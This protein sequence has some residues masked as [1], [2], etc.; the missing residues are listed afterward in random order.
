MKKM[1]VL[2][3]QVQRV[4]AL[5]ATRQRI[6]IVL[7]AVAIGAATTGLSPMVWSTSGISTFTIEA[8][9]AVVILPEK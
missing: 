7:T 9:V 4:H 6:G 8:I 3:V 2:G 1:D 5:F